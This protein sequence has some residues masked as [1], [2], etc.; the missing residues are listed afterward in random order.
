MLIYAAHVERRQFLGLI[1]FKKLTKN[2]EVFTNLDPRAL[3]PSD[4]AGRPSPCVKV[5]SPENEDVKAQIFLHC[6]T[7]TKQFCI[8]AE[9]RGNSVPTPSGLLMC[10]SFLL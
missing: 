8:V 3:F 7:E 9:H 2:Q 10:Y 1:S 4:W 5:R 6:N